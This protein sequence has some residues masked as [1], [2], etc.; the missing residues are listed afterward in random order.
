MKFVHKLCVYEQ[1]S[2]NAFPVEFHEQ[3]MLIVL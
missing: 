2:L 1:I 3:I